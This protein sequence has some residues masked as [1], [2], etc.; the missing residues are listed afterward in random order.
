MTIDLPLP[1]GKTTLKKPSLIRVKLFQLVRQ[2]LYTVI[3]NDI[4]VL[5]QIL[6][7]LKGQ[8]VSKYYHHSEVILS[9][10]SHV[11]STISGFK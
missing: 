4:K 2:L 6:C 10:Q 11:Q 9:S 3:S 8:K 5:F 1:T 7:R